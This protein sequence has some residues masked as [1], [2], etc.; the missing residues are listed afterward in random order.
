MFEKGR[1]YRFYTN[2]ETVFRCVYLTATHAALEV[3]K[4]NGTSYTDS[5]TLTIALNT[6]TAGYPIP[7][8]TSQVYTRCDRPVGIRADYDPD[9]CG[10]D[11]DDI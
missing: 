9:Q 5:P 4:H 10:D 7:W 11:A 8:T 3:Y 2:S 6:N 1:W